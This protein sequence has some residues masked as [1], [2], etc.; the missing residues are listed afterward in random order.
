MK[1]KNLIKVTIAVLGLIFVSSCDKD[2][3]YKS[4]PSTI[5]DYMEEYFPDDKYT[6][7]EKKNDVGEVSYVVNI[8]EGYILT[9]DVD[10]D[11]YIIDGNG[12][13][14]EDELLPESVVEFSHESYPSDS[15]MFWGEQGL[16]QM[17]ELTNDVDLYFD[18]DGDFVAAERG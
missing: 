1:A 13:E 7:N 2:S 8:E 12:D 3:V 17:V 5:N 11:V 9:F 6:V 16:Y 10:G 4:M 14:V 18:L 15:I